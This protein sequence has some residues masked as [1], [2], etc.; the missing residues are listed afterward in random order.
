LPEEPSIELLHEARHQVA[1]YIDWY[2][3]DAAPVTAP[4]EVRCEI[5]RAAARLIEICLA[6]QQVVASQQ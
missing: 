6:I 2:S 3:N 5:N 1:T 4:E